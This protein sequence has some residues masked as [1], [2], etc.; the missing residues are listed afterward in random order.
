MNEKSVTALV[1]AAGL[2][3]RAAMADGLPK[4]YRRLAGEAMLRRTVRA[5]LA[6]PRVAQV[7]VAVSA[8]DVWAADALAG[9]PRTVWRPC[10]GPTR[11]DT[12]CAALRD[13]ALPREAWV[14]VHDA[15]RPGL[16]RE[17]LARLI[18][19]CWRHGRGGLL[20]L[21]VADTVKRAA[22]PDPADGVPPVVACTLARE[23]LWL[24]QTPQMFRAGVLLDALLAS[25]GDA[26]VT[27]EA[28]A[29][30][31]AGTDEAPLLVRGARANEKLT[32]PED[33]D[34]FEQVLGG[35]GPAPL[36]GTGGQGRPQEDEA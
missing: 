25:A 36:A 10:G 1:P 26:R 9:L 29:V 16:S 24:A 22:A 34:W 20:A 7:R 31:W 17:A 3:S 12:V 11:A 32:W 35:G 15:A 6:E 21:P 18:D 14:M 19:A 4:Q 2:G 13:A 23:G 30:E 8:A 27:D 28:S 5:L 33:F